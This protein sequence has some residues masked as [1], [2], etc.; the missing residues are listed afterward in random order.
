MLKY[1]SIMVEAYRNATGKS[2]AEALRDLAIDGF[3]CGADLEKVPRS[4]LLSAIS[5]D[6][7]GIKGWVKTSRGIEAL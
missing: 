7:E 6:K 4:D 3:V 5:S 2:E 1:V